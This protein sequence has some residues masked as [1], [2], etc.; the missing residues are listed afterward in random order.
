[1]NTINMPGFTAEVTFYRTNNHYGFAA[2][3]ANRTRGQAVIPQKMTWWEGVK[4]GA[5]VVGAGATCASVGT[6]GIGLA[7]CAAATVAAVDYCD[8]LSK[9]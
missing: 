7:A 3:V 5:A 6:T 4:C 9:D 2:G 8:T 1:M